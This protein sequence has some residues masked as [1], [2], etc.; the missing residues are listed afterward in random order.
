[1]NVE[2]QLCS[3]RIDGR[4]REPVTRLATIKEAFQRVNSCFVLRCLL[5]AVIVVDPEVLTPERPEQQT[6]VTSQRSEK[7]TCTVVPKPLVSRPLG[8]RVNPFC[9]ETWGN[10]LPDCSTKSASSYIVNRISS[11]KTLVSYCLCPRDRIGSLGV[12]PPTTG[13]V[14]RHVWVCGKTGRTVE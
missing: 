12:A 10:P 5:V 4:R 1:M 8:F 9:I 3:E 14:A 6:M 7:R 11:N 2:V 13:C